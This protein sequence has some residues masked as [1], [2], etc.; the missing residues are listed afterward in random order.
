MTIL[1]F[2]GPTIS[3]REVVAK[4]E[5]AVV[6][7]PP[8]QGDILAA[9][10]KY[11]PQ[12]IVLIDAGFPRSAWVSE[13]HHALR[14]GV[15][16]YGAGVQ[17]ALRA[18]ELCDY[19]MKGHG[20]AFLQIQASN[21]GDDALLCH[22]TQDGATY[23]RHTESLLTIEAT[24][25]SA[26]KE[27]IVSATTLKA[28]NEQAQHL[29]WKER[30]WNNILLADFFINDAELKK[31]KAW[32]KNNIVDIAKHDAVELL[33]ALNLDQSEFAGNSYEPIEL[34]GTL[35]HVNI[36][37]RKVERK[38][39]EVPPFSIAHHTAINHEKPLQRT[40]D[41]MN[42]EV[43]TFFAERMELQV[44]EEEL[45]FERNVIIEEQSLAEG[46]LE[47]WQKDND[48][49]LEDMQKFL[50]KNALCRKM[51]QWM[52]MKN[53]FAKSTGPILDQLRICGEY[54]EFAESA[55]AIETSKR[56]SNGKFEAE[57]N[58]YSLEELL[59]LRKKRVESE[60]TLPWVSPYSQS[61]RVLGVNVQE[62]I[63]ELRRETFHH[64][65]GMETFIDSLLGDEQE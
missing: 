53:G 64:R 22:Y 21:I 65:K 37:E 55:A 23:T 35:A 15:S 43:V 29:F 19:G 18:A 17:G 47:K 2:C 10:G 30:S 25:T 26:C 20:Q 49:T 50:H 52:I 14:S 28:L 61:S 33:L 11:R 46:R 36:R 3:E 40:F 60:D 7:P 9:L 48:L 38:A 45:E 31:V 1:I 44:S 13:L 54:P 32:V 63:Y 16:V 27:G 12:A 58:Q 56:Q 41:A 59:A 39:G 5:N 34:S 42:R 57:F 4:L 62:L 51:H 8:V 24:L 6:L